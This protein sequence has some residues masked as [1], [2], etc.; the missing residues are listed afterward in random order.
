MYIV[1]GDSGERGRRYCFG[2]C[3]SLEA[4]SYRYS[5][6]Y[7]RYRINNGGRT[8][9]IFH[10][11]LLQARNR[12]KTRA[13]A[14]PGRWMEWNSAWRCCCNKIKGN[15][16]QNETDS[17][18]APYIHIYCRDRKASIA[19]VSTIYVYVWSSVDLI[20]QGAKGQYRRR[21]KGQRTATASILKVHPTRTYE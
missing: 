12:E 18:L 7:I 14:Y 15:W 19:L 1:P 16:L 20:Q 11:L 13:L 9:W 8:S 4:V 5:Y 17:F 3:I 21:G 10:A 6:T 2:L